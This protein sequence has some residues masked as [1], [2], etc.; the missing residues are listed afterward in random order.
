MRHS[1]EKDLAA[2][3]EREARTPTLAIIMLDFV[4]RP[5]DKDVGYLT[6]L[7][8]EFSG[9]FDSSLKFNDR[10]YLCFTFSKYNY[11]GATEFWNRSLMYQDMTNG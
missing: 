9:K 1:T 11:S 5:S 4:N 3:A 10:W 8:K 7:A 6:K 2:W